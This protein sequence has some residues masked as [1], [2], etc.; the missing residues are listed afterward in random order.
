MVVYC[1]IHPDFQDDQTDLLDWIEAFHQD[2]RTLDASQVEQ[3]AIDFISGLF[4]DEVFSF[5]IKKV[6][7]IGSTPLRKHLLYILKSETEG[8]CDLLRLKLAWC[9]AQAGH[10]HYL[11]VPLFF[12]LQLTT[13]SVATV[14]ELEELLSCD[15]F[16]KKID[17]GLQPLH[18]ALKDSKKLQILMQLLIELE[19]SRSCFILPHLLEQFKNFHQSLSKKKE[20]LMLVQQ[21]LMRL[22][23][24]LRK[25]RHQ[26]MTQTVFV[27]QKASKDLRKSQNPAVKAAWQLKFQS[28]ETH[29]QLPA[30]EYRALMSYYRELKERLNMGKEEHHFWFSEFQSSQKD[31]LM[32]LMRAITLYLYSG[33]KFQLTSQGSLEP[34]LSEK[35]LIDTLTSQLIEAGIVMEEK[36]RIIEIFGSSRHPTAIFDYV[37]SA[38]YFRLHDEQLGERMLANIRIFIE[39]VCKGTFQLFRRKHNSTGKLLLPSQLKI[40]EEDYLQQIAGH[41]VASDGDHW[42][43]LFLCGVDFGGSCQDVKS[44][45]QFNQGLMGYCLDGKNRI[46]TVKNHEGKMITRAIIRLMYKELDLMH[47]IGE[48]L[49]FIDPQCP[50]HQ[51]VKAARPIQELID[52]LKIHRTMRGVEAALHLIELREGSLIQVPVLFLEA[53]YP[54]GCQRQPIVDLAIRKAHLMNLELYTTFQGPCAPYATLFAFPNI[55]RCDYSDAAESVITGTGAFRHQATLLK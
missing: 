36:N 25:V 52:L 28:A 35:P 21:D 53:I 3:S 20:D 10:R 32:I 43:D 54:M 15:A 17:Q 30:E 5:L 38:I 11:L 18:D 31:P 42:E 55:T 4:P 47:F 33:K 16:Q 24:V 44:L 8:S 34:P 7:L 9:Q 29:P 40:Y 2:S 51:A 49:K 27:E 41:R 14:S 26:L 22:R 46:L 48:Q 39:H 13:R 1:Y 12:T 6:G 50:V 37:H 23:R 19:R 45:G